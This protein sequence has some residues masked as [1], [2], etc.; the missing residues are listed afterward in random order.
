MSNEQNSRN[1]DLDPF[2]IRYL[3]VKQNHLIE[4]SGMA[5]FAAA[6]QHVKL[7]VAPLDARR[8]PWALGSSMSLCS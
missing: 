8:K 1:L 6:G 2:Q 5:Y 4:T 7:P 3:L